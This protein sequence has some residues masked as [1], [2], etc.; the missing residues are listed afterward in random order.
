MSSLIE[1]IETRGYWRIIIRPHL[2][3]ELKIPKIKDLYPIIQR[4][5]VRL[6]G[7]DF[8]HLDP[9][10]GLDIA[11]DWI[12]QESEWQHFLSLWRFYQSGQFYYLFGMAFDWRDKSEWWPPKDDWEPMKYVGIGATLFQFTEVLEFASRLS[13]SDAGDERIH[14][15]IL[16]D[17]LENRILY[18]DDPNRWQVLP[19]PITKMKNYSRSLELDREELIANSRDIALNE[20]MEFFERFGWTASS[21]VLREWQKRIGR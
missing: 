1:K 3:N 19:I 11:N 20:A 6:R 4:N 13:L 10:K 7:W 17:N 8:P 21:E 9:N 14:I 5:S 16:I 18:V 15:E 12:G 2:F